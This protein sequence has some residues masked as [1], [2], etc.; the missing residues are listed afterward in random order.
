MCVVFVLYFVC[1]AHVVATDSV[2]LVAWSSS[3]RIRKPTCLK[4][5]EFSEYQWAGHIRR[6]IRSFRRLK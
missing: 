4:M 3:I 2:M 6:R 5:T 1:V